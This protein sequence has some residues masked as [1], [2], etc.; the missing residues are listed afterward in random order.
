MIE[1]GLAGCCILLAVRLA[2]QPRLP[3][4]EPAVSER[5]CEALRG[6]CHGRGAG[7]RADCT[8]PAVPRQLL[9][10]L[11]V[12]HGPP[13]SATGRPV[14]IREALSSCQSPLVLLSRWT[15]LLALPVLLVYRWSPMTNSQ[16]AACCRLWKGMPPARG[17]RRRTSTHQL[18]TPWEAT[19]ATAPAWR[20]AST[21]PMGP[22]RLTALVCV[23]HFLQALS[24]AQAAA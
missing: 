14:P 22:T 19:G 17:L 10:R 11:P 1:L 15:S 9:G 7:H 12:C 13:G 20:T 2:S 6:I 16:F 4:A 18:Q 3:L 8:R 5:G 21:T 24:W 23:R